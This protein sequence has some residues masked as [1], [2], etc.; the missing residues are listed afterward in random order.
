MNPSILANTIKPAENQRANSGNIIEIW[1]TTWSISY[2]PL[3]TG[4][5]S[6]LFIKSSSLS[7]ASGSSKSK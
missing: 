4:G 7:G 6:R 1:L 3:S 2:L 5:S